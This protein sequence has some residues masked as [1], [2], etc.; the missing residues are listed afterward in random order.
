[1]SRKLKAGIGPAI[2]VVLAGN[3]WALEP[4]GVKLTEGGVALIPT[5]QISERWD[6][7]IRAVETGEESSFVTSIT[8]AFAVVAKGN[9]A[10][11][12]LSYSL[13]QDIFHSSHEDDNADHR[14]LADAGLIF[15]ARHRL[16]LNAG[17]SDVE[18]TA[19]LVQSLENDRYTTAQVGSTYTYGAPTARGQVELGASYQ[20][21]RFKNELVLPGGAILNAD[22][23]RDTSAA[24]STLYFRVAPKTKLLLEGRF[25]ENEYVT[26]TALDGSNIAVLGGVTWEAT[27]KT[28]GTIKAGRE[29]K[30][31]DSAALGDK[32]NTMWEAGI[33]WSPRSYSTFNLNTR[34]VFDEGLNGAELIETQGASLSWEHQWLERLRSTAIVSFTGQEYLGAAVPTGGNREDE[35]ADAGL[36]L[37]YAVRRWLDVGVGYKYAENDSTAPTR[38]F[39]RNIA[40]INVGLSL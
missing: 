22:R 5:L 17:F 2:A 10:S 28:S 21:L 6:D 19:S 26:N 16:A 15:T 9:K 35:L 13:A 30:S 3:S 27:A 18:E 39:E 32:S 12:N 40:S 20:R 29:E 14:L 7:N 11:F 31:F 8:P 25:T 37:T 1:M 4:Q 38:S 33:S 24:R 36:S 34:S 23:E